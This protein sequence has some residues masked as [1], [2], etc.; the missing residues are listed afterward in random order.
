MK[1]RL[2]AVALLCLGTWCLAQADVSTT[3]AGP[4]AP[5]VS[6]GT[7]SFDSFGTGN[8]GYIASAG[9]YTG[10]TVGSGSNRALVALLQ[11]DQITGGN[12]TSVTCN[13]DTA[14]TNQSMTQILAYAPASVLAPLYIFGLVAPTSGNKTIS[15][16][17]STDTNKAFI[18]TIS[19]TGVNQT[20]GSTSFPNTGSTNNTSNTASVTVTSNASDKAVAAY[21][22]NSGGSISSFSDTEMAFNNVSGIVYNAGSQYGTGAS[23]K[24]LTA[25][26]NASIIWSA[27]AVDVMHN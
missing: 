23:S 21:T 1:L 6:G 19:F 11:F 5:A 20:G 13:W 12:P 2:L 3:G 4:S 8:G 17:W 27:V 15:C 7:V 25:N 22:L 16:S 9:T 26:L 14:G 24:T 10:Q 18:E